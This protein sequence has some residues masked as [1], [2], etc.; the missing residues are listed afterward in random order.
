MNKEMIVDAAK[1]LGTKIKVKSPELLIA[2]GIISLAGAM[3]FSYKAGQK[4]PEAVE[5]IAEEKKQLKKKKEAPIEE[6]SKKERGRDAFIF[7]KGAVKKVVKITWPA[8]TLFVAGTGMIIC[9]HSVMKNR[10]AALISAYNTLDTAYKAYRERVKEVIGEEK[11]EE[12]IFTK[13]EAEIDGKKK[14]VKIMDEDP[15]KYSPYARFFD[16]YNPNWNRDPQLNLDYLK[17]MQQ[18]SHNKLKAN[19]YLFLNDVY[20]ALGIPPTKEGQMVGWIE[21]KSSYVDFGIYDGYRRSAR[22]FVNGAEPSILLDFNVAGV[23]ID[24]FEKV[25]SRKW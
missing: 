22:E 23:I 10:N 25:A 18:I 6:Y 20:K 1:T 11:A 15:N 4:L 7:Y 8:A 13:E 3:Y 12:L 5:A 21:G 16:E 14:K 2:G 24:D 19:G 9:S 17:A